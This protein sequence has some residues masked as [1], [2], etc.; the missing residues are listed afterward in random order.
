MARV[1]ARQ[2]SGDERRPTYRRCSCRPHVVAT[3]AVSLSPPD[4]SRF[5]DA[6]AAERRY[7]GRMGEFGVRVHNVT[8]PISHHKLIDGFGELAASS[9]YLPFETFCGICDAPFVVHPRIQKY[10]LEVRQIPVKMLRRGAVFCLAC[11]RRRSRL[12]WLRHH[13]RWRSTPGGADERDR[14]R[15]E[16]NS[17]LAQSRRLYETAPWPYP[18]SEA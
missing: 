7:V 12:N 14:L 2:A 18:L 16:E 1:R 3:R 17:A 10:M 13:D 6:T 15:S 8:F 4:P 11:R 9:V 5:T